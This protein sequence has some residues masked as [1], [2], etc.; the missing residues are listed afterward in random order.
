LIKHPIE[1]M[2]QTPLP[3]KHHCDTTNNSGCGKLQQASRSADKQ[4]N[5]HK[6]A[7]KALQGHGGHAMEHDTPMSHVKGMRAAFVTWSDGKPNMP[8]I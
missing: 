7:S 5:I 1:Q 8:A 4:A 3:H 6:Q 2:T